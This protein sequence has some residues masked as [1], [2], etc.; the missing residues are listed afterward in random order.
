VVTGGEENVVDTAFGPIIELEPD[1][2]AD[3]VSGDD[4]A[5]SRDSYPIHPG[6]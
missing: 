3:E 4:D 2:L 1:L 5:A 6:P